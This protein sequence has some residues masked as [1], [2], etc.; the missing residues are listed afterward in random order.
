MSAGAARPTRLELVQK[1]FPELQKLG[2]SAGDREAAIDINQRAV[3]AILGDF[4]GC[5]DKGYAA[6]GPGVLCIRLAREAKS[7]QTEYLSLEDI[8]ADL[9][10]A[11]R[12]GPPE[13]ERAM[14]SVVS[15]IEELNINKAALVMV[16]DSG[17]RLFPI[18]RDNPSMAVVA[19][20]QELQR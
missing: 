8:N 16:I 15:A 2:G 13:L 17:L 14:R 20:M 1:R 7:N 11:K 12:S 4:I 10:E 18:D 19:L 5:F 6:F 3:E 9:H